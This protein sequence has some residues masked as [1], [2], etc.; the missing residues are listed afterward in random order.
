MKTT[1]FKTLTLLLVTSLFF[2][3]DKNDENPAGVY[4]NG[5]F[6]T[7][8]GAFT[9]GNASISFYSISGDSVVND[10]FSAV[11]NRP[12]GDVLQSA[13][14]LNGKTYLV[15]NGSNKI[16][17]VNTTDFKEQGV[18]ESLDNPRY[19]TEK[20]G[21]LYVTQ[22][23]ENGVVKVI[24][25]TTD[26]VI[27]TIAVG[28]G[29]EMII[30]STDYLIAANKGGY[31]DDSTV[32]IIDPAL[33]Q[34]VKSIKTGFRPS[35]LAID[36]NGDLWVLNAGKTIYNDTWTEVLGHKPSSLSKISLSSLEV[37]NTFELAEEMHPEQI[38][39]ANDG[40]TLFIGSGYG[41]SGIFKTDISSP[42]IGGDALIN[43]SAYGIKIEPTSNEL[44]IFEAT[45][46]TDPGNFHRYTVAGNSI[47]H[48]TVGIFPNGYVQ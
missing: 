2:G 3:C 27:K 46:G 9:S 26:E 16:E 25:P 18:I 30:A 47:D 45:N 10:I 5:I 43:L 32:S 42:N 28:T 38:E 39:I 20:N 14:N 19:I 37:T 6:I 34:V 35:D 31:G 8:E 22:W 36:G 29:P 21:L 17:I 33:N 15:L 12:L 7:N 1:I 24:D 41:F 44:F 4:D 11:N 48:Y 40:S 23:G 13:I